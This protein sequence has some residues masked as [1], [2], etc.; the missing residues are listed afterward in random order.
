MSTAKP[1]LLAALLLAVLGAPLWAGGAREEAPEGPPAQ[2][3]SARV[4]LY[5]LL[6]GNESETFAERAYLPASL[7]LYAWN[8]FEWRDGQLTLDAR[9]G[10]RITSRQASLVETWGGWGIHEYRLGLSYHDAAPQP[11]GRAYEVSFSYDRLPAGGKPAAFLQPAARAVQEGIRL[12][13]RS[14]G[15]VRLVELTCSSKGRFRALV[16]VR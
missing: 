10:Y 16:E 9:G 5:L 3:R 6:S 14:E 12:S 2:S 11:P 8:G 13:G 15:R 4:R 7:A 1:A